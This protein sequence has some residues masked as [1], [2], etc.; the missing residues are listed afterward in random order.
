VGA[1]QV[2]HQNS[3]RQAKDDG[4]L[5]EKKSG[6]KKIRVFDLGQKPYGPRTLQNTINFTLRT[7][8]RDAQ[9]QREG[10]REY[11]KKTGKG[12]ENQPKY[13]GKKIV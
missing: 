1:S 7:S 2:R 4:G 9:T 11:E 6:Q 12:Q 5:K 8:T 3:A 13:G 10:L